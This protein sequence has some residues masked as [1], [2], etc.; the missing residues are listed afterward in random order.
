MLQGVRLGSAGGPLGLAR[1]F[2]TEAGWSK[3]GSIPPFG[4]VTRIPWE[5][6]TEGHDS[7]AR[8]LPLLLRLAAD[9]TRSS[10]H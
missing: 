6:A 2:C 1:G 8:W 9:H 10:C 4:Q 5:R 3:T 7:Q